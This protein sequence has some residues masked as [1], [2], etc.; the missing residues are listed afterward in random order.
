MTTLLAQPAP[1]ALL[2]E[3]PA[4]DQEHCRPLPEAPGEVRWAPT[5]SLFFAVN[6]VIFAALAVPTFSWGAL[7]AAVLTTGLCLALGHS[8]GLHR[9]LIHR[10]FRMHRTTGHVLAW[11]ATLTGIGPVLRLMAMHD[12]RDTWQNRPE[13]PPYYCYHHPIWRDFWLYLHC[14]HVPQPGHH[15]PE[16][17]EEHA[18]DPVLAW[19]DRTWILQQLPV[20]LL[21]TATLGWGGLVW[22]CAGRVVLSQ[23]GHWLVNYVCHTTG[24]RRFAIRGAGE[25]GR[26]HWLFGALSMGE[27][28]HNNHHAWPDS[29]RFGIGPWEP[30]P[31][32]ACIR[33][34]EWLGLAWEV[35]TMETHPIR[36]TARWR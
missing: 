5:K 19:L 23:V 31:G 9:G 22:A 34:M 10:T 27:G 6:A 35:Q 18:A 29:A 32:F 25:E 36:E 17:P 33:I 11:L 7:A 26:N 8:V 28:W 16:I 3:D 20:A 30:D 15:V 4:A 1:P 13:A 24:T 21:L 14:E 12:V 2:L